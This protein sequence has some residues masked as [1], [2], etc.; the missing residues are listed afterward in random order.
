MNLLKFSNIPALLIWILKHGKLKVLEFIWPKYI[1]NNGL[2]WLVI[3]ENSSIAICINQKKLENLNGY[4]SKYSKTQTRNN[5]KSIIPIS[6][7]KSLGMMIF[8]FKYLICAIWTIC[9]WR[10]FIFWICKIDWRYVISVL[11]C[12][13]KK[14]SHVF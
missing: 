13:R 1:S 5:G 2:C 3:P 14:H 7:R 9:D 10:F 12:M 4:L 8:C 6:T 11:F